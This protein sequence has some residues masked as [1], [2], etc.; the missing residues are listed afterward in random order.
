MYTTKNYLRYYPFTVNLGKI[1]NLNLNVFNIITGISESKTLTKDISY[2]CKCKFGGKKCNSNQNWNNNKCWCECKN[3]KEHYG[4]K[5]N[6]I[7]NPAT[8]SCKKILQT[9]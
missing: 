5:K 6:Y 3:P 4:C 1:E 9:L 7:W 2:K 8:H